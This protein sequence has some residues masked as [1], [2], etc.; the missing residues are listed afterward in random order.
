MGVGG[1]VMVV[2]LEIKTWVIGKGDA[3]KEKEKRR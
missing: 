3:K 2:F 1:G